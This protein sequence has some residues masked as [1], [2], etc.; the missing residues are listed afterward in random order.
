M[1]RKGK[2][3]F[4]PLKANFVRLLREITFSN[5]VSAKHLV[6]C[7]LVTLEKLIDSCEG[8]RWRI[9]PCCLC[10]FL[11]CM[12]NP[13]LR[14]TTPQ[15]WEIGPRA[16]C[17]KWGLTV[18]RN[19]NNSSRGLQWECHCVRRGGW[20]LVGCVDRGPHSA[21]LEWLCFRSI[22]SLDSILS[23]FSLPPNSGGSEA[24]KLYYAGN[25]R[26]RK[27]FEVSLSVQHQPALLR[28]L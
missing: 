11:D 17:S 24:L 8:P 10:N 23:L 15:R 6:V 27:S 25:A 2:T 7:E 12:V 13:I 18:L 22:P 1:F 4:L 19:C 28:I 14:K 21:W 20:A 26:H 5:K 9:L 16:I 3:S